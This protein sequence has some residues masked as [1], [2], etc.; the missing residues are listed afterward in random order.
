M[1]HW[2]EPSREEKNFWR[3][4]LQRMPT[5]ELQR[6]GELYPPWKL[7]KTKGGE[8]LDGIEIPGGLR[9]F[10]GAVAA[11]G[12]LRVLATQGLNVMLEA[13]MTFRVWPDELEECVD[14]DLPITQPVNDGGSR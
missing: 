10:V 3:D 1:I 4:S 9:V 12:R 13:E 14:G 2:F 5:P 11:D 7:W 8:N 6:L